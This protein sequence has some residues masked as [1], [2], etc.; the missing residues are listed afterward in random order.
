MKKKS[1]QSF[2]FLPHWSES[3]N[4]HKHFAW[5]VSSKDL[6][7]LAN[8]HGEGRSHTHMEKTNFRN[9]EFDSI[10]GLFSPVSWERKRPRDPSFL[11]SW[12]NKATFS[13]I[14]SRQFSFRRWN[15]RT[16]PA[17]QCWKFVLYSAG[18]AIWKG[19][20]ANMDNTSLPRQKQVLSKQSDISLLPFITK[21]LKQ[22]NGKEKLYCSRSLNKEHIT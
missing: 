22:T 9:C 19:D 20:C 8:S 3:T 21:A 15:L 16:T 12:C 18:S 13:Q 11:M 10:S 5:I 1:R 7:G 17:S 6:F 4:L 14:Y 2:P